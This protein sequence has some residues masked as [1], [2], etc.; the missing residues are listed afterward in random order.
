MTSVDERILGMKFDNK[1]FESGVST[2]LST[3]DKLKKALKLEGANKGLSDLDK[4]AKGFSLANIASGVESIQG[5]FSALSIAAITALSNIVN[6]AVDAGIRITK[7]LTIDPIAMGFQ[8]YETQINAIQTILANTASKGTNL[9]DVNG[10]L[11]ELNEY[12]DRT[13]YNFTE[14]SRNI[15]TFTAAGVGLKDST[16]AIK[17]IANLAA[18]SGSNSQ[19]ASTAMYQLSQAMASGTV[20]L[21]DWNSV[22]NAG[23]GGQVFQ[24]ALKGTAR[25]HGVNIDKMIKKEGSFRETLQ[26]GWLT[27]GVLTET[28][29]KFTGDLTYE[30]L[31]SM[32]YTDA[33]AKEIL[34][35]GQMA[36]DAATKVKTMTQL[37][38]TLKEASQSGWTQTWQILVGDFEEAKAL[39]TSISNEIGGMIGESAKAR[40]DLLQGWKDMGGRTVLLEGLTNIFKG[41]MQI[42]KPFSEAM[43]EIFPPMTAKQLYDMTVAF[44]DFTSG[45]KLSD[46]QL[47][48]VKSTFKGFFAILSIAWTIISQVARGFVLLLEALFPMTGGLLSASAGIGEFLVSLDKTIKSGDDIVDVFR[49]IANAIKTFV[50]AVA[51]GPDVFGALAAGFGALTRVDLSGFAA[52]ITRLPERMRSF[53]PIAM[54]FEGASRAIGGAIAHMMP[55]FDKFSLFVNRAFKTAQKAVLDFTKNIKFDNVLDG[56]NTGMLTAIGLLIARFINTLTKST[57]GAGGIFESISGIFDGITDSLSA[58]QSQLKAKTL[59]QIAG[60]IALLAA[61]VVVLSLI[62]SGGLTRALTAITV[63]LVQLFGSMMVF[64]ILSKGKGYTGIFKVAAAMVVLGTALNV[65][66][67]AV[68]KLASLSWNELAKG[69]V[70]VTVLMGVM[71]GTAKLLQNGTKGLMQTAVGLLVFAA[72]LNVMVTAVERLGSLD[73]ATLAK[74]LGGVMIMM[75][76]IALFM[77]VTDF[78]KMG[79]MNA[80]GIL[81]LA[82]ALSVMASAVGKMG[83]LDIG[84]LIQG[85][86]AIQVVMAQIALFSKMMGK[87][88]LLGTATSM[89]IMGAAMNVLA[90]AIGKLG[91]M[92]LEQL[93]KGL[94]AMS[95]G[96]LV[97]AGAMRLMPAGM[98][99]SAAGLVAVS[100]ALNILA[101]AMK[102]MGSMQWDEIARGMVVLAGSLAIIALAMYAMTGALPGAAA[103]IIVAASL[104][105]IAPILKLLGGMS[106]EEIGKGLLLLAGVFG[107]FALAGLLMGPLIPVLLGVAAA[108]ALFGVGALAA[109]VGLLALSLGLTALA[110]SGVAGATALVSALT[111]LAGLIPVIFAQIGAGIV[112]MAVAIGNGAPAM[113]AAFVKILLSFL[114]AASI[115]GPQIIS[116]ITT[117]I[118]A[119]VAAVVRLVPAFVNAGMA[120]L[121]GILRGIA[122]NIGKVVD[123]AANI[124]VNFIN[125]ISRNLPRIVEAGVNLIVSFVE[126]LARSIRSNSAR[127]TNAGVDL[128]MAIIDG[129][130]GGLARGVGRVIDAARNMANSAFQA[131]MGALNAHSPSKKFIALGQWS[132]EGLAIGIRKNSDLAEGS[133]SRMANNLVTA[134]NDTLSSLQDIDAVGLEISPTIT[135]VVDLSNV[136]QSAKDYSKMFGSTLMD[137]GTTASKVSAASNGASTGQTSKVNSENS[138]GGTSIQFTQNIHSPKALSRIDIYRDT[139]SQLSAAREVLSGK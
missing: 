35:L 45:L 58:M 10:A 136:K 22:V 12:A 32:K 112:A 116:T 89:V 83:S 114:S 67:I 80:V 57:K 126:G 8:E 42:V 33:Q 91:S 98:L 97:I 36:N 23:M 79:T 11:N 74:G 41:L 90:D 2:S 78:S 59:M 88:N 111:M 103:L 48:Q 27:T 19:Q 25:A 17:G 44:R 137:L 62:D 117:L 138:P 113:L 13:I 119:L 128:A 132:A 6:R 86:I 47:A 84:T 5:K 102:T 110:V 65:L 133:A 26:N 54:L 106:W 39:F 130:V 92:S 43:R 81:V 124:V 52:V 4:T 69:L 51:N 34:K 61:A 66:A 1:Q 55:F 135:P 37:M 75:G 87:T 53:R 134:V 30:Q 9:K 105:I 77:K 64:D 31:R 85:L 16:A 82:G 29:Q 15:G 139:R 73:V 94:L 20:K 121:L 40:N 70:G 76:S 131:A 24:D 72:A 96:L 123:A 104:A 109:G 120:I 21:M 127:M 129:M 95:A 115:V 122:N 125:G 7:S 107:V 60:A 38:D 68:A 14:M 46:S 118:L 49:H 3:L 56:I 108:I 28:L 50:G 101:A 18:V 63:M 99:V 71:A 93:G 100:I